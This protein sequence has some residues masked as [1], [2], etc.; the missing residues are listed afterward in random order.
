[1]PHA[2]GAFVG[3]LVLAAGEVGEDNIVAGAIVFIVCAIVGWLCVVIANRL[4][5]RRDDRDA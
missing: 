2:A 1:M 3:L 5:E 4:A